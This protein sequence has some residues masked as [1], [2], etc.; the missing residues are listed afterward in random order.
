M[1][2]DYLADL[3][4]QSTIADVPGYEDALEITTRA[5]D[6]ADL[7]RAK[8]ELPGVL[9][10]RDGELE[11]AISRRFY[12]DQ[13]GRYLGMDIYMPRPIEVM[14]K[15][16]EE[17][18][19]ALL[20]E[21]DLPI[22]EA[23]ARGLARSRELIYEPLVVRPGRRRGESARL[24]DFEDLLIADSRLTALRNDQ[25]RQI[26]STVRE[27]LLLVG[28][29]QRIAPESSD[30]VPE[31]LGVDDFSGWRFAELLAQGLDAERCELA[32]D[33]LRSLFDPRVIE[34]LVV[35]INPL[36]KV[37]WRRPAAPPRTLAFRFARGVE[38]RTIRRVLVQ[39]EDVTRAEELAA[40]VEE[41]RQRAERRLTLAM[42]A[43]QVE[44]QLMKAFLA[45]LDLQVERARRLAT[46]ERVAPSDVES[47]LRRVHAL[48]GEAGLLKLDSFQSA[49]HALEDVLG[50]LRESGVADGAGLT[51][52]VDAIGTLA[53]EARDLLGRLGA[54]A[55][56]PAAGE[57]GSSSPRAGSLPDPESWRASLEDLVGRVAGDGGKAARLS[58]RADP[59]AARRHGALLREAMVQLVRNAVVHGIEPPDPRRAAGK[60]PE[61]TVQV[62]LR[63][64]AELGWAELVVQDDGGG[65]DV[66][67]IR[68]R[69]GAEA[70]GE[71]DPAE[72]ARWIFR[73]GFS[74][75]AETSVHAGRGF[76]LDLV[77]ERVE[78]AGG[79]IEVHTEPGRY[80]AFRILVPNPAG[81][82][83]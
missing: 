7:L 49:L 47:L 55:A 50:N 11:S 56:I 2:Q 40:E 80:T 15:R 34:R 19:G 66:E 71:T 17:L 82:A 24:I 77:K 25:M 59:S 10:T 27:G 75:A 8:P 46:S 20:I 72:L 73:P 39:V 18:G 70:G 12:L 60:P 45:A 76:G 6:L 3:T 36:L 21:P 16:F 9:L 44:P 32:R 58:L 5:K 57:P 23:V 69:V 79:S 35:K 33:Y 28:P 83:T 68:A 4:A 13:V 78:E 65:L 81:A 26:L 31:L 48:K 54:A 30:S 42:A 1:Q 67:A 14:T 43:V 38:G 63:D 53:T 62:E 74:T 52:R 64:H 37:T 41:E 51:P 29:D 61:G 22:Q